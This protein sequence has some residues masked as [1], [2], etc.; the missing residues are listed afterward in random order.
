[1]ARFAGDGFM[2]A[3]LHE[4]AEANEVHVCEGQPTSHADAVTKSRGS[5][6][7]TPGAGNGD[8]TIGAGTTLGP[9]M[10]TIGAMSV[11]ASSSDTG[12][13]VFYVALLD[14]TTSRMLAQSQL[15]GIN[16]VTSG[17]TINIASWE[18]EPSSPVAPI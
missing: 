6:T 14:S 12:G 7:V 4:I 17:E 10:L 2:D 11:V 3:L 8:F 16:N 1:M 9:R 18:I 5:A 15:A 13:T